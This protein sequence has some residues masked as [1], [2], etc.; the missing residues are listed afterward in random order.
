MT[1]IT[2]LV[3]LFIAVCPVALRAEGNGN[4]DAIRFTAVHQPGQTVRNRF[5]MKQVGS[6]KLPEPLPEQKF[7]Q[8]IE[9]EMASRCITVNADNSAT[10]EVALPRM[11]MNMNAGG[12]SMNF[13]TASDPA[14]DSTSFG[15]EVFGRIFRAIVRAGKFM[16]TVSPEGRPIKVQGLADAMNKALDGIAGGQEQNVA[17]KALIDTLR[18]MFDDETMNQQMLSY[19]R[20]IPA[21]SEARIGDT[22]KEQW[23]FSLPILNMGLEGEGEYELLGIEELR[24]RQCAKIRIKESFRSVPRDKAAK[25]PS[26]QASNPAAAL[27]SGM[28]FNMQSSGGDGIAYWDYKNGQLVQLRQTQRM[29]IEMTMPTSPNAAE[30]TPAS[31]PSMMIQKLNNSISMD[32]VE[33]ADA[34]Q[35]GS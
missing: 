19:Y 20:M 23:Q 30:A 5:V 4:T 14:K 18:M 13:D 28:K 26:T 33:P 35:T 34:S 12:F 9:Q 3:S 21:R 15:G 25:P 32:L 2:Y 27:L 8:T 31:A 17:A 1:R 6:M 24:G 16:L 7:V 22:W 11:A 29:T 10:Y